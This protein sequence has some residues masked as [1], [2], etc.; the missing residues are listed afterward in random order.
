M[1]IFLIYL[2]YKEYGLKNLQCY[3]SGTNNVEVRN[4]LLIITAKPENYE[5]KEFTSG[6]IRQLGSGF[7]YGK[8]IMRARLPS[9]K[10]LWPAL[11]LKSK[12]DTCY[13]EIDILEVRGQEPSTALFTGHSGKDDNN[14]VMRGTTQ[15]TNMDFSKEFH[16]FEII[17]NANEIQW[18]IDNKLYFKLSSTKENWSEPKKV[19]C[20]T[21][22]FNNPENII[23]NLAVGGAFFSFTPLNQA[24]AKKFWIKSTFEVDYVKVYQEG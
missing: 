11:W 16:N 8:F 7:R 20:P 19:A 18:F 13:E 9:G 22:P 21:G 4:G 6:R 12:I 2:L 14:R 3:T 1:L 15:E 10:H 17:W 5:N 24:E 23:I